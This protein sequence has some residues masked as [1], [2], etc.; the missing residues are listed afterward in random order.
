LVP[1]RLCCLVEVLR[2][3]VSGIPFG[4][5]ANSSIPLI[6]TLTTQS[7]S[8]RRA[9]LHN[10][11]IYIQLIVTPILASRPHYVKHQYMQTNIRVAASLSDRRLEQSREPSPLESV[12]P[13]CV[14]QLLT[15]IIERSTRQGRT[16]VSTGRACKCSPVIRTLEYQSRSVSY[17]FAW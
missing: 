7:S 3:I 13:R 12:L 8:N 10:H 4:E 2:R 16:S 14:L 17:Y 1:R 15:S 9:R 5:A 11:L 6:T